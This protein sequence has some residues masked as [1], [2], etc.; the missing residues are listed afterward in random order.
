VD[1]RA[2]RPRS[3]V[4]GGE[5]RREL[6]DIELP[7]GSAVAMTSSKA[8]SPSRSTVRPWEHGFTV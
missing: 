7:F 6:L 1:Q 8:A 3:V 2:Q 5:P 4:A